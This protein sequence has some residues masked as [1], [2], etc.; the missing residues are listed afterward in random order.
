MIAPPQR[1]RFAAVIVAAGKGLRAG[2]DVPKQFASWRGKPV[3]RH[4]TGA[5]I[6]AGAGAVAVAIPLAADDL[7][8][9][10][11]SG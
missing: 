7:A 8:A 6:D 4:A 9:E 11:L 5:L 3:L 2:H 1:S 10:V